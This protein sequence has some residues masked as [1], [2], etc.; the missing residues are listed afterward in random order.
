MLL[1]GKH[2][3]EINF[4]LIVDIFNNDILTMR[5]Q[6]ISG[7]INKV[8]TGMSCYLIVKDTFRDQIQGHP[9]GKFEKRPK[10]NN[11]A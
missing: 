2:S 5:K 4:T 8:D 10:N 1:G 3:D 11:K 6:I 9:T 7:S